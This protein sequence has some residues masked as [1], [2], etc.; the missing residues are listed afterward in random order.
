MLTVEEGIDFAKEAHNGQL[1][2]LTKEPVVDHSIRVANHMKKLGYSEVDQV[3]AVLHK[4]LGYT[5]THYKDVEA[6]FGRRVGESVYLLTDPGWF[7]GGRRVKGLRG[8]RRFGIHLQNAGEIEHSILL[9]SL[10]DT[11][12][13][14]A[15]LG[16]ANNALNYILDRKLFVRYLQKGLPQLI[17]EV[18][19]E[20][21]YHE[22]SLTKVRVNI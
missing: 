12:P 22:N 5:D 20:I 2:F 17:V 6:R 10:L 14:V 7:E 15:K 9:C 3:K 13:I 16:P 21:E 8:L 1:R 4:V 19:S 18:R 11:I